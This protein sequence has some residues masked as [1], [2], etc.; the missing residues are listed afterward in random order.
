MF[1]EVKNCWFRVVDFWYT[2]I[3]ENYVIE[4]MVEGSISFSKAER[5][6]FRGPR[7]RYINLVPLWIKMLL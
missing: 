1:K 4:F 3:V 7:G 6:F 5:K 2:S